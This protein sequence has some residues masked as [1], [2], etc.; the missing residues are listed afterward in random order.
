MHDRQFFLRDLDAGRR[1]DLMLVAAVTSVLVIR[2]YLDV[3]G[4]PKIGG[5]S[6]HIAHMLWGG[7]LMVAA[8]VLATSFLGRGPR[9][10]AAF[11]GGL[12]FGTFID[13]IG[14]LLTHDNDYFYEPAVSLIYVAMVLLYLAGRSLHRERL[15]TR[16]DYLANAMVE[17]LEVP[18]GDLDPHEQKR[19]L[20]Y[21]D[22]AGDGAVADHLRAVFREAPLVPVTQPSR[23]QRLVQRLVN[24]YRRIAATAWFG[25]LLIALFA[26]GVLVDILRLFALARLLP[27]AGETLLQVPLISALP[28][29]TSHYTLTQ[30]LQMG[31]TFLAG[32]FAAAGI[33]WVFR[34]RLMALRM[35]QRSIFVSLFLTQV[36]IFY[37][38]QWYGL[39][40]LAVNLMTL[41]ALRFMIEEERPLMAGDFRR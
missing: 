24:A 2:F 5:E 21:L 1:L 31:S 11:L 32:I 17:M 20:S 26:A 23:A 16:A 7:L 28:L 8:L 37:R 13:E 4:Y 41:V 35:F 15:A 38:V 22:R 19:A 12:G 40:A 9:Q 36:F 6:L 27:D 33:F 29:D 10:W 30:W 39:I 25:R 3:T 34:D 18:R 14:K